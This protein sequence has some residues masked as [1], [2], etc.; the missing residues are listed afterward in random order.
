MQNYSTF[1]LFSSCDKCLPYV[2]IKMATKQK[3]GDSSISEG[4]DTFKW[5]DDETELLL[6]VTC[7]YEVLKAAEGT[8]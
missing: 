7:D 2:G 8:D 5:T 4:K 6:K 3:K 1:Q